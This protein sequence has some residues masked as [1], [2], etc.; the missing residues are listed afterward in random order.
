MRTDVHSHLLP[1][2]DDGA[3][4]EARSRA[5]LEG[6]QKEGLTHL[7]LTPHFYPY[8]EAPSHFLEKRERAWKAFSSFSQGAGVCFSLGAEVYLT[9]TLFNAEDLR[10]LCY[11]N[12]ELIL[13]ELPLE[14]HLT[15]RSRLLLRRLVH[16]RGMTPVIAHVDRYPYLVKSPWILEE[17]AELGCLF[18]W[19]RE[20]LLPYFSRRRV[21]ELFREGFVHFFG[22]D[23]HRDLLPEKAKDKLRS[24]EPLFSQTDANAI[25]MIFSKK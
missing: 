15:D 9:E 20:S 3:E 19:N 6:M 14:D 21:R 7:A 4:N 10:P 17:L 2:I 23:V 13:T 11:E 24:F 5:L 22:G 12:T 8:R 25:A 16:D 18:Q 1:K